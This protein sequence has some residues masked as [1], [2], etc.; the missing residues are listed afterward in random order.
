MPTPIVAKKVSEMYRSGN[1]NH[2]RQAD[3]IRNIAMKN[4]PIVKGEVSRFKMRLPKHIEAEELHGVAIAGMMRAIERGTGMDQEKFGA[5]VRQRVRGAILDELR[6]VD[7]YSR[8]VRKKAR[9]YDRVVQEV[10]QREGRIATNEEI[11]AELGLSKDAYNNMMEELRPITF[12]S[13]DD[14]MNDHREQLPI[15]ER[16]EDPN[17]ETVVESVETK[18]ALEILQDR[19]ETLPPIQKKILHMYYF[20]DFRLAEIA[21]V[22]D[23]SESRICQLHT[24]AIRGLRIELK[25]H[26]EN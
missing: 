6:R 4:L 14:P 1:D 5:Y 16:I 8:S 17:Q 24:Q 20:K 19:L 22:F 23:L 26:M 10:E 25:R 3:D 13:F 2:D 12:L 15:S 21:K 7:V 9:E 18:E 11:R